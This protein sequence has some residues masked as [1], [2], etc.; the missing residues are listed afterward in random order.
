MKILRNIGKFILVLI[1]I[2][3]AVS[4]LF[5][6]QLDKD[7]EDLK[8]LYTNKN[9]QFVSVNN[10]HVHYRDEGVKNDSLPILLIHGTG[11]SLHTFDGW[12]AQLT[13][14]KRV[15]RLDLPGFGLTGPFTH[16]DYSIDSY[17]QFIN[18]FLNTINVKKC[19]VAGNSL[20]G[21]IAWNFT[22][23]YPS[24]V[25]KLVL[26]DATGYPFTPEKTPIAFTL[27]KKPVLNK[28]LT[29][30]TPKFV[31]RKSVENVYFDTSKVSDSLVQRYFDL[32][33]RAGNRQAL[34]D[35]MTTEKQE[36]ESEKIKTIQQPTLIL[37]GDHDFLVPISLAYQ[38][39]QDLPNSELVIFEN[40]GHVP[41]EENPILS[42]EP[43]LKFLDL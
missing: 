43:V 13:G 15:I 9:S 6:V 35:R 26:I 30:L 12:T 1:A 24:K 10:M 4:L 36:L 39:H 34:V 38:F 8:P 17:A 41:M 29:V 5:F 16:T 11:A 25:E 42:L 40:L 18:S 28:L 37:W 23:K 14:K 7:V 3:T 22:A 2:L 21:H 19:M 27:A 20:G 32:T 33:L 31:V